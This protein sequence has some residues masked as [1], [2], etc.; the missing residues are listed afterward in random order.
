MSPFPPEGRSISGICPY[1]PSLNRTRADLYRSRERAET[2]PTQPHLDAEA[3]RSFSAQ[4]SRKS[5]SFRD[6][7]TLV[8]KPTWR[9]GA[10]T[11]AQDLSPRSRGEPGHKFRERD[12]AVPKQRTSRATLITFQTDGFSGHLLD[13]MD[14]EALVLIGHRESTPQQIR[15][16]R[17]QCLPAS[18]DEQ[19]SGR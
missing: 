15:R 12:A 1:P 7:V 18:A 13:V 16:Q 4:K 2:E 17:I 6:N 3:Q 9:W 5:R 10:V 11:M 8:L 19:T 14:A